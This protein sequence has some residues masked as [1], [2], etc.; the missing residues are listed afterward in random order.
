[1]ADIITLA[2]NLAITS[3][4]ALQSPQDAVDVSAYDQ[5]DLQLALLYIDTGSIDF[6]IETSM[7]NK[8]DDG[9]W[10]NVGSKSGVNSVPKW[11]SLSIPGTS[12]LFRY[13]RYRI[14]L[15]TASNAIISITG[16]AR[17]RSL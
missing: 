14:T 13:V 5:L 1:M 4:N 11:E 15:N 12:L 9:S 17:R 3:S 10:V 7:Q 16:M 2:S 6:V 8:S